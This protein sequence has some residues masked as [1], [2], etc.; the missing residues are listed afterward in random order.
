M[1]AGDVAPW[2]QV[3]AAVLQAVAAFVIVKLTRR[4]TTA[5]EEYVHLTRDLAEAGRAQAEAARAQ[6]EAYA[7]QRSADYGRLA[8]LVERI[9]AQVRRLPGGIDVAGNT[10]QGNEWTS[11]DLDDL[12]GVDL[13]T[14]QDLDDLADLAAKESH[15]FKASA[16]IEH[17]RWLGQHG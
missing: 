10:R 11:Q 14:D 12:C 6:L 16:A 5:T 17:L 13:W 4:L 3:F 1:T 8:A 9:H 7:A 15:S 2:L